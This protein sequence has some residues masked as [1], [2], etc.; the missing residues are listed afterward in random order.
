MKI[1]TYIVLTMHDYRGVVELSI[2]IKFS[3]FQIKMIVEFQ[4]ILLIC[5]AL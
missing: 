1:D 4:S 2:K 5:V 3:S